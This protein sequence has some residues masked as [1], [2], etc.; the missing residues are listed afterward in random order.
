MFAVI[1]YGSLFSVEV[2][3]GMVGDFTYFP[4]NAG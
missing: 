1:R 4:T 2:R 3:L